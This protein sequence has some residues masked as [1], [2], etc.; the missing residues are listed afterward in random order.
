MDDIPSTPREL[1]GARSPRQRY[2]DEAKD[3]KTGRKKS[4][5]SNFVNNLVGAPRRPAISAPE[6][7]VHVTHVGY[8]QETGEFTVCA[9]LQPDHT[10]VAEARVRMVHL[11]LTWNAT[12]LAEG[13]ATDATGQRHYRTR[14][15]EKPTS[16]HRCGN[17]L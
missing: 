17:L 15:E 2:S 9:S 1:S 8:D 7:P 5:F 13:M 10:C 14:T 11:I 6:N 16:H 3:S 4:G 12:G